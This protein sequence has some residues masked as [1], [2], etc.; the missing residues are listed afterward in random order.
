MTT[1]IETPAFVIDQ[2][3]LEAGLAAN[4]SWRQSDMK[5]K[6]ETIEQ[7][8]QAPEKVVYG[9]ELILDL[10]GCNPCTFTRDCLDRYFSRLCDLI[11]MEKCEVH[12][13]D[14][15]GLPKEERQTSPLTKGTSAV[16]FILTSTIVVH[17]LDELRAVYVNIFS[18]QEFEPDLPAEV[19]AKWFEADSCERTFIRRS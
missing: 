8:I 15:L 18:C 2:K 11:D 12:Y 7:M 14:D 3:T 6:T 4:L 13:W 19:T 5:D 17:T 16:C 10:H 9:W 1:P